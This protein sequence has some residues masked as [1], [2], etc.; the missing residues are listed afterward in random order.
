M[1]AAIFVWKKR[2]GYTGENLRA[3]NCLSLVSEL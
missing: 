2:G 3:D 1:V